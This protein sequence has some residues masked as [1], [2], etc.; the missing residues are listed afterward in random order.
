MRTFSWRY[1]AYADGS[2]CRMGNI[3]GSFDDYTDVD[4]AHME[5]D[6]RGD[7]TEARESAWRACSRCAGGLTLY[8]RGPWVSGVMMELCPACDAH[9]PAARAFLDWHRD[10]DRDPGIL[11]QLFE[12]WETETMHA[13]GWARAAE[14]EAPPAQPVHPHLVPRGSG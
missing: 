2:F 8:W 14:P 11:P 9:K 4:L 7:D 10:P 3:D 1:L 12:D 5:A 13:H 6:L